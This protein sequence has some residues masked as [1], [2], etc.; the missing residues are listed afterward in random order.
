MKKRYT[1]FTGRLRFSNRKY[2][3]YLFTRRQ[4]IQK[5]IDKLEKNP[6]DQAEEMDPLK[7]RDLQIL[8]SL[9][10]SRNI[11]EYIQGLKQLDQDSIWRGSDYYLPGKEYTYTAPLDDPGD[12]DHGKDVTWLVAHDMTVN[13]D[14]AAHSITH[15]CT[16]AIDMAVEQ[17]RALG[18]VHPKP[19]R[20]YTFS[21][22]TPKDVGANGERMPELLFRNPELLAKV[23]DILWVLDM[24]Y[25]IT[26]EKVQARYSSMF[27]IRAKKSLS[28]S[29]EGGENETTVSLCDLGF[30]VGQLLPLVVQAAIEKGKTILVEQPETHIHPGLQARLGT[31]FANNVKENNNQ[32]IIETHSEHLI[33]R[34]QRL[35]RKGE[36]SPDLVKVLYVDPQMGENGPVVK[37]LK[38]D[39]DGEFVDDWPKGFFPERLREF[40]D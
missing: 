27:E 21:G 1:A 23:N 14:R 39:I 31:F 6:N 25:T 19:K 4:D 34:L 17:C 40:L 8:S 5:A 29:H 13:P 7:K 38:M 10:D 28:R 3:E 20:V 30:G 32:F 22:S 9:R 26:A 35:V 16:S 2:W 15:G 37:E 33:L 12:E 36:L 24:G 11:E 18:S